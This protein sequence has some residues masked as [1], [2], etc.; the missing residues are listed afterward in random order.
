MSNAYTWNVMSMDVMPVSQNKS[1]V[2]CN[3]NWVCTV[4]SDKT[5]E[6]A[7]M[8]DN[9]IIPFVE[10]SEFTEFNKLTEE[11]VIDWVQKILG[12][13]HLS[14]VYSCLDNLLKRKINPPVVTPKLP[15]KM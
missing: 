4:R 13:D 6:I 1:N 3:V 12:E 11:Q 10:Q 14:M 5:S 15:W 2:V 7:S 8:S 9:T